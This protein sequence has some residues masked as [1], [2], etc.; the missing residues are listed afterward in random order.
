ME[1]NGGI[2][3]GIGDKEQGQKCEFMQI[4]MFEM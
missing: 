3:I 1:F 4:C 2:G